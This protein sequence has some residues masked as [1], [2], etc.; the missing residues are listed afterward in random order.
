MA[1]TP[2][3]MTR[4]TEDGQ[5][6]VEFALTSVILMVLLA[7]LLDLSRAFHYTIGLEG[8][9][10]AGARHGAFFN[11]PTNQQPYL[12]DADIKTAVDQVLLGDGLNASTLRASGSCISPTDGNTWANPPYAT[13]AFPTNANSPWLYIC[14]DSQGPLKAGTKA[15]PPPVG[16]ATYTGSDLVVVVL[17]R[18]G[19]LGGLSSEYLN[20]GASLLSIPLTAFQHFGVQG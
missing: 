12:D 2:G 3:E 1:G 8:A 17:A 6:L 7:G 14:Y 13:T 19:L 11:T 4:K 20:Q 18:Y 15:T 5:A 16:D 9:A 10:R